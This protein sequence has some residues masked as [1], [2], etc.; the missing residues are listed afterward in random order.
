M[1]PNKNKPIII[2]LLSGCL[3]IYAMVVIGGLTR[4]THSGLSIV[5]WSLFGDRPPMSEQDWSSR[6]EMYKQ[7]PEYQQVNFNFTLDEFKSIFWWEY[8]HRFLGRSI[9]Y[10]FIFPMVF[11]LDQKATGQKTPFEIVH[12]TLPGCT[13]GAFGL[14]YG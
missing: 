7:F 13:P 10:A 12:F 2:W 5:N 11:F 3:L 6:F 9:G 1:L 8:I 14:V 4:L